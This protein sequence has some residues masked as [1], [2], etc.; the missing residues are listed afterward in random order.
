MRLPALLVACCLV[1]AVAPLSAEAGDY[2]LYLHGRGNTRWNHSVAA[3]PGWTNVTL[4][5]DGSARLSD[6]T[7]SS[8]VRNGVARYCSGANVCVVV[9][10]SAGCMRFLKAMDE[11]RATGREPSVLWAEAAGSSAGGTKLAEA[12]TATFFFKK[13]IDQDMRR[14]SARS[15]WGYIQDAMA[16]ATMYHVAGRKDQCSWY[17]CGNWVLPAGICDGAVCADSAGGASEPGSFDDGCM[18]AA[19]PGLYPGRKWDAPMQACGGAEANHTGI[20]NV[21]LRAVNQF[22]GTR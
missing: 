17:G 18:L 15:T 14:D 6:A 2:V 12:A 8:Q 13:P 19:E 1:A 22:A 7:T 11:L 3:A 16:P 20:P 21:A 4:S 10:H 9:C 5:Y